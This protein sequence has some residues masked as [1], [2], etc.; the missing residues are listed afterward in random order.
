ME[1]ISKCIRCIGAV[2]LL[3]VLLLESLILF[4]MKRNVGLIDRFIRMTL[5]GVLI[6]FFLISGFTMGMNLLAL[7]GAFIM[8]ATGLFGMCPLYSLIGLD[9]RRMTE[10]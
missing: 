10:K 2:A 5:G 1:A 3:A 7:V 9:T 8:F 4:I 6:Y